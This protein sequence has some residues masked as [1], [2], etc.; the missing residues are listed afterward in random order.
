M[1]AFSR[2]CKM[3]Y[4]RVVLLCVLAAVFLASC[5]A[6]ADGFYTGEVL[7]SEALESIIASVG[8]DT[9]TTKGQEE[10]RTPET[11]PP[12]D[13]VYY[14]TEKGNVWHTRR[15]C[16][17]LSESKDVFEGSIDNAVEAGKERPCS[18]CVK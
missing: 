9:P 10:T 15:D 4:L 5:D 14:W 17:Y 6:R 11:E 16:S 8:T 2:G 1:S 7:G 18:R 3:R 13:G 12:E